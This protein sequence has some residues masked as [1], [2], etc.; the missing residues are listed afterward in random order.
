MP[1][2]AWRVDLGPNRWIFTPPSPSDPSPPPLRAARSGLFEVRGYD[3]DYNVGA[4]GDVY[5]EYGYG[6]SDYEGGGSDIYS[7]S[8]K[9]ND[10]GVDPLCL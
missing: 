3:G 6:Y 9:S 4:H 7:N 8:V 5:S 10:M 1:S 2:T